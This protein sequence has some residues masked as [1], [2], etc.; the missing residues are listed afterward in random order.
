[1]QRNCG[2]KCVNKGLREDTKWE[3][4][5][6]E[7]TSKNRDAHSSEREKTRQAS[8]HLPKLLGNAEEMLLDKTKVALLEGEKNTQVLLEDPLPAPRHLAWLLLRNAE[9]LDEQEEQLLA[10]LRQERAIE[11]VY[12]LAQQFVAMVQHRQGSYFENWLL[13]CKTCDIPDVQ[14]FAE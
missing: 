4:S 6:L 2:R 14:T 10:F 13:A 5:G 7:N 8:F 12:P 9:Q 1:M 11:H 3:T